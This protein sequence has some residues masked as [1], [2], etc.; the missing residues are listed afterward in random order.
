MQLVFIAYLLHAR[1]NK[2][3]LS[4]LQVSSNLILTSACN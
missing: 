3:I 4:T 1:G 2:N